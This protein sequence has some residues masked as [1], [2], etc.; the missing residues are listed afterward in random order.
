MTTL[1]T[2]SAP[3]V[4]VTVEIG[5]DLHFY[6]DAEEPFRESVMRLLRAIDAHGE[7]VRGYDVPAS[8]AEVAGAIARALGADA[9]VEVADALYEGWEGDIILPDPGEVRAEARALLTR[10]ADAALGRAKRAIMRGL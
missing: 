9:T 2:I 5:D 1:A 6:V 3:R 10:R 4:G 7:W 8:V